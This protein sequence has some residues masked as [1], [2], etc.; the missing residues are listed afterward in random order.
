MA[1]LESDVRAA[2]IQDPSVLKTSSSTTQFSLVQGGPFYQFLV[3]AHLCGEELQFLGR[4]IAFLSLITWLPLAVLSAFDGHL[5]GEAVPV[6]FLVDIDVHARCLVV[7]PLLLIAEVAVHRGMQNIPRSFLDRDFVPGHER[8]RFDDAV[9]SVARLRDSSIIESLLAVLVIGIGVP[10]IWREHMA[11]K[12]TTWYGVD[13]AGKLHPS[14]AGWWLGCVT[15]PFIQFLMLRWY[16]RV[17]IWARFLWKVSCLDLQLLATNPDRAAGLGFL[18]KSCS[19]FL[20]LAAAHGALFSGVFANRI[21][22]AGGTLP[23]F[24]IQIV[25]LVLTTAILI[26]GPLLVFAPCLDRVKSAS[27]KEYGLLAQRYVR[28]FDKKWVRG[29][30]SKGNALSGGADIQSLADLANSLDIIKDTKI[31][32]ISRNQALAIGCAVI[33]PL[34]PLTLT[35]F[36]VEQLLEELVKMAF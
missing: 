14:I 36:S 12:L 28:E 24:K 30:A 9:M 6:P 31:I 3:R 13:E 23:D 27:T 7:L 29:D 8:A 11:L 17:L 19:V 15:L 33:V 32:L 4:R 22:Y 25:I 2:A 35:M 34:L 5:W 1:N 18:P 16:F 20:P 21:V 26:L 10:F